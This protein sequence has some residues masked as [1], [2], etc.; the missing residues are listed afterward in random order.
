MATVFK[1]GPSRT[2]FTNMEKRYN[3]LNC[4]ESNMPPCIRLELDST[5]D[6]ANRRVLV[7]LFAFH[8]KSWIYDNAANL[9]VTLKLFQ[10]AWNSLSLL[11]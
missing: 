8:S 11:C 1:P 5:D 7:K 2:C 6:S 9:V 4:C 10:E 3:M